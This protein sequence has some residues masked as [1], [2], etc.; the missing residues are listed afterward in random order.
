MTTLNQNLDWYS[1]F[2]I[3]YLKIQ[4]HIPSESYKRSDNIKVPLSL[5]VSA[6]SFSFLLRSLAEVFQIL[7]ILETDFNENNCRTSGKGV[8]K[9]IISPTSTSY[10]SISG[11][12]GTLLA[13]GYLQVNGNKMDSYSEEL[14]KL[15]EIAKE[16]SLELYAFKKGQ[17]SNF[18]LIPSKLVLENQE[19][20]IVLSNQ[21]LFEGSSHWPVINKNPSLPKDELTPELY[22]KAPLKGFWS[23]IGKL[24]SPMLRLK[25]DFCE[26]GLQV[27]TYLLAYGVGTRQSQSNLTELTNVKYITTS[28]ERMKNMLRNKLA[29]NTVFCVGGFAV[30]I[31]SLRYFFANHYRNDFRLALKRAQK[32]HYVPIRNGNN[33]EE[34]NIVNNKGKRTFSIPFDKSRVEE[35][36]RCNCKKYSRNVLSLPCGHLACCYHCIVTDNIKVCPICVCNV[37]DYCVISLVS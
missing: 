15:P 10:P 23:F 4:K 5:S 22:N 8:Y 34:Q 29:L 3:Q 26:K 7:D 2:C 9:G 6:F 13:A 16:K 20:R 12:K 31:L 33:G 18:Y 1:I 35:V 14:Y 21:D 32:E 19:Q 27:G 24:W 17:N 30:F 28:L 36:I 37:E 11:G 25:V